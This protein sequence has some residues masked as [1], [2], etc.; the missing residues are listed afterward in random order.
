MVLKK[1]RFLFIPRKKN[2]PRHALTAYRSHF[3]N[4]CNHEYTLPDDVT[5]QILDHLIKLFS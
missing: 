5:A 2:N 1:I 4:T 3:F